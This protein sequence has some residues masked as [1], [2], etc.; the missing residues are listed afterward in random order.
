MPT[1]DNSHT[2]RIS[3]VRQLA[4]WKGL[5]KVV[6]ALDSSTQLSIR[7]G[8]LV[9]ITK[10][11]NGKRINNG[12]Q[13]LNY[14]FPVD[15]ISISVYFIGPGNC[16]IGDIV[17]R[18]VI[19]ISQMEYTFVSDIPNTGVG[20]VSFCP[21]LTFQPGIFFPD[22]SIGYYAMIFPYRSGLTEEE[23]KNIFPQLRGY[24]SV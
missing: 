9:N 1:Q 5:N 20:N 17:S 19:D 11:L 12:D 23:V 16:D 10:N 24:T 14:T 18:I 4:D 13:L 21:F 22:G 8:G 6:R 2:T 15:A 3:R 7:L